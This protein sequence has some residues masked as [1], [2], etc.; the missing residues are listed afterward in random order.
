MLLLLFWF[1]C[2]RKKI[3]LIIG[4]SDFEINNKVVLC[5]SER[6]ALKLHWMEK[7]SNFWVSFS[8]GYEQPSRQQK[9]YYFKAVLVF[10][11]LLPEQDI[12]D[13]TNYNTS[14]ICHLVSSKSGL[15]N[16]H[17]TLGQSPKVFKRSKLPHPSWSLWKL[18]IGISE[19]LILS[20]L[21]ILN[22]PS[23]LWYIGC[24]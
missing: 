15:K 2:G 18:W 8:R 23:L 17:K 4:Q 10:S 20:Y 19:I 1:V 5:F 13:R 16:K 11:F 7:F 24:N 21:L 9:T 6:S 14:L 22:L 12:Y 3:F